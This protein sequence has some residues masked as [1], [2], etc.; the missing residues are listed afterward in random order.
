M[1]AQKIR[2]IPKIPKILKFSNF[3]LEKRFWNIFFLNKFLTIWR[4]LVESY[5][6]YILKFSSYS[7]EIQKVSSQVSEKVKNQGFA[8]KLIRIVHDK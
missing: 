2:T 7:S 5:S 1:E 4:D 8:K 6:E 3:E